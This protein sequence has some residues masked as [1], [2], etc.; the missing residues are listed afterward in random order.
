VEISLSRYCAAALGFAFVGVWAGLGFATAAFCL[1]ACLACYLGAP[2]L[3]RGIRRASADVSARLRARRDWERGDRR[4]G[5]ERRR[6]PPRTRRE[7]MPRALE[8]A[9]DDPELDVTVPVEAPRRA[10]Y[11]W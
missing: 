7:Q 6:R 10:G 4:P 8:L 5:P 1:V 3:Q 2:A 9:G 11:G